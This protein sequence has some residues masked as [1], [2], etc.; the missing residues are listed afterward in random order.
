M[1]RLGLQ[2]NTTLN[3]L[4]GLFATMSSGGETTSPPSPPPEIKIVAP[5]IARLSF[6]SFSLPSN[7]K[8]WPGFHITSP[9]G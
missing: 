3:R 1:P 6:S 2:K 8:N 7:A 5:D 9:W 4:K